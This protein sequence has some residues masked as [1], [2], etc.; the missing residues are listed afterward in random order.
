MELVLCAIA[1]MTGIAALLVAMFRPVCRPIDIARM[2]E[3]IARALAPQIAAQ[4]AAAETAPLALVS[5]DRRAGAIDRRATHS[6]RPGPRFHIE[7]LDDEGRPI[8][9]VD[10]HSDNEE[11]INARW[12]R[13][14]E[15]S[16]A[17]TFTLYDRHHPGNRGHF[18]RGVD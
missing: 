8:P 7:A 9:G 12:S 17:G 16:D 3:E 11:D 18:S 2:V 6:L 15:S 14:H 1:A 13:L 4:I 5:R 10:I